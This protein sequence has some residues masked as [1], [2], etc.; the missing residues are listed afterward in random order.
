MTTVL[1]NV[2]IDTQINQNADTD[3]MWVYQTESTYLKG[4]E[5]S[6]LDRDPQQRNQQD[7]FLDL[8]TLVGG[9]Q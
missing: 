3:L 4:A 8:S 1:I 7:K 9:T 2:L 6:H 5:Q